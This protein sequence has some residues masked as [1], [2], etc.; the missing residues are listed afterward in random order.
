MIMSGR[1]FRRVIFAAVLLC[2]SAVCANAQTYGSYAP[3]SIFG[4][5]D[6]SSSGTAYNKS[7]GGVGIAGRTNRFINV[8]N[9]ASITERDSLSFMADFSLAGDN[10]IFTQGDMKSVS[11]TFNVL[12][13]AMS[14]PIYKSL[15]AMFGVSPYSS[16]GYNYSFDYDDPAII[17]N[18]GNI[19]YAASGKGALY[20]TY[21]AL[22]VTLFDRLSLGAEAIF[23]FGSNEKTYYGL[24]SNSSYNGVKNGQNIQLNAFSGKFGLQYEQPL[25]TKDKLILGATYTMPANLRGY[26]EDYSYSS[27]AAA[28]DTLYHR[29]DTLVHNPGKLRLAGEVGVGI[30]YTHAD[31]FMIEMDYTRSDW[32]GCGFDN[33]PGFRGNTSRSATTSVFT[34]TTTQAFRLGFE[35]VPNRSDIRYYFKKVAYRGGAYYKDEY[36]L[37][38]GHKINSMGITLGATFPVFKWYNGI[39]VAVDLGQRGTISDNLIRERYVNFS[40]GMNIFDIWFHKQRYD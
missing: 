9:P 27:G 10:K 22:G 36:Y 14:F 2:V 18:A 20:Q 16:T 4:V 19:S 21:G 17:G 38:D 15:S 33:T 7:M 35:I 40:V 34:A 37:L 3:Y 6:L 12:D 39:T 31:K 1:T 5:G 23:Y 32:T 11:N 26:I 24:F 25:G 13:C 28:V 30:C 29:V 8:L